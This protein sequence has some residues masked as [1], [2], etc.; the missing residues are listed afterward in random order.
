MPC[1]GVYKRQSNNKFK[2]EVKTKDFKESFNY[3]QEQ[4]IKRVYIK[5]HFEKRYVSQSN[6]TYLIR[7][8]KINL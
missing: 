3:V 5:C 8:L 7:R 1:N 2:L 6:D 4:K